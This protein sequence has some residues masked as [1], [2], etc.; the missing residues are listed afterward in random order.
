MINHKKISLYAEATAGLKSLLKQTAQA[1]AGLF[2]MLL[3]T[4]GNPPAFII[5]LTVAGGIAFVAWSEKKRLVLK[6]KP[7]SDLSDP[8]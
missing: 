6:N 8:K 1:G 7:K 5:G 3:L 2:I 4:G